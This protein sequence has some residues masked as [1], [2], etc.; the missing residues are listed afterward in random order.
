MECWFYCILYQDYYFITIT[1][2]LKFTTS[3][4][5]LLIIFA[6][7]FS[8][9]VV[10]LYLR[11]FSLGAQPKTGVTFSKSY[12]EYLGLNWQEAYL[13][14]LD[15]LKV[16]N[17][18]IVAQW[19]EVE[20]QFKEY[21]FYDVGWMLD[22]AYERNVDVI[23][24]IGRRTPRWPEC[25]DPLWVKELTPDKA[26]A[27]QL[28][29]V[30]DVVN[31]FKEKTALVMWQVEN[32]PFLDTFGECQPISLS[33]LKQEIALVKSLD[34]RPVMITDSGELS[35]WLKTGTIGDKFGHTLYREVYNKYIGYFQHVYPPAFYYFKAR[36]AGIKQDDMIV[37]ELQAEPWVPEGYT[38]QLDYVKMKEL[39]APEKIESN[40]A[41]AKR[42]G[43]TEIYFWGVEWWYWM[44]VKVDD[45]SLW[46]NA[47]QFF[48]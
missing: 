45:D 27:E 44:K 16:K 46:E 43:A 36:L 37:A 30:R 42:T 8:S 2:N 33:F 11:D 22:R 31:K 10:L 6:I 18:R 39:M 12:A 32:E 17:I 24:A 41:Y 14:T 28:I 20:S 9:F 48:E 25:H 35:W 4:L 26:R 5:V 7:S 1:M 38:L 19:N 15:E 3:I 29:M 23:L 21:N 34:T 13:A 40:Y 47:K